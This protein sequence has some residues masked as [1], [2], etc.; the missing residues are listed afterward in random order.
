MTAALLLAAPGIVGSPAAGAEVPVPPA[1]F[2]HY[3]AFHV[4]SWPESATV[5]DFTGDG[6]NDVALSTS[7][8]GEDPNNQKVILFVQQASGSLVQ[9]A[10]YGTS[11]GYPDQMGLD[12]GDL[13]GDGRADL[14]LAT[15]QG[16]DVFLGGAGGL[17][18]GHLVPTAAARHVEIADLDGDGRADLVVAG[19]NEAMTLRGQGDGTFT[20][21]VVVGSQWPEIEVADVTGDGRV[22]IVG[23]GSNSVAVTAQ[24]PDG[25]FGAPTEYAA[26]PPATGGNG[27]AVGDLNGDGRNDVALS[28]GG[29]RPESRINVFRQTAQGTLGAPVV[30]PSWDTP[31]PVE[32][33]DINLDGRAD[34]VVV[35]G[36]GLTWGNVGHYVQGSDGTLG[37][38]WL[39][40]VPYATH[41][42]AKGLD[43]GDVD[44]DRVSDIVYA[45]Y[46]NGLVV[47]RSGASARAWGLG[48]YGQVGDG[49]RAA[50]T[51]PIA[52]PG[53]GEVKDASAGGYHSLA[54]LAD[55]T[56]TS[57]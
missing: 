8:Y 36:G 7:S 31:E 28:I 16:V 52:P 39:E 42:D 20:A 6:R 49:T 45:D 47:L 4:G 12:A 35:H 21:P 26:S 22:D 17:G 1:V 30:Y 11:G 13:N 19:A 10:T 54:V 2:G 48:N 56:V 9:Q 18:A 24:Q 57:W 55:G 32:V 43:L 5:G 27:I 37:Q 33:G 25:T 50:R 29:S 34:L 23:G 51:T 44:G 40:R 38:E 14:A 3:Q 15:S 46:N 53:I 41:Y